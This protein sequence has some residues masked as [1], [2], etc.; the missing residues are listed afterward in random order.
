MAIDQTPE[1]DTEEFNS[2]KKKKMKRK[3]KIHSHKALTGTQSKQQPTP[4]LLAQY[5]S[6]CTSS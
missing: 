6:W 3:K 5:L 2:L 4:K 1:L